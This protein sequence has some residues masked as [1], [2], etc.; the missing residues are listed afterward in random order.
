[1]ASIIQTAIGLSGTPVDVSSMPYCKRLI[2]SASNRFNQDNIVVFGSF[3]G[4]NYISLAGMV[5]PK[6]LSIFGPYKWLKCTSPGSSGV[7]YV[8]ATFDNDVQSVT[9]TS[10]V[11]IPLPGVGPVG[12]GSAIVDGVPPNP[13]IWSFLSVPAVGWSAS[14]VQ[15]AGTSITV[16]ATGGGTNVWVSTGGT[17]GA[18]PIPAALQAANPPAGTLV[19]DNTVTWVIAVPWTA[20]TPYSSTSS[21]PSIV[22]SS[23]STYQCAASGVSVGTTGP[24]PFV[25][26]SN[27][28]IFPTG[29]PE[30]CNVEYANGASGDSLFL[31]SSPDG[32]NVTSAVSPGGGNVQFYNN[33]GVGAV[34]L[35]QRYIRANVL[36]YGGGQ[37]PTGTLTLQTQENNIG[38]SGVTASA[39]QAGPSGII[40]FTSLNASIAWIMETDV[41]AA[42]A[43]GK[44]LGYVGQTGGAGAGSTAGGA[45]GATLIEGGAGGAG[46]SGAAAGAGGG[47]LITAGAAGADAGGGGA[48][49]G[50]VAIVAGAGTGTTSGGHGGDV[51]IVAGNA[52]ASAGARGGQVVIDGGNGSGA[53]NGGFVQLNAGQGGATGQ[54]AEMLLNGGP[55]GATSGAGGAVRIIGGNATT[56]G[57]GGLV[58]VAGGTG[59][60]TGNGGAMQF[61]G[62]PSDPAVGTGS[63]GSVSLEGGSGGGFN[64]N[65]GDCIVLGGQVMSTQGSGGNLNLQGGTGGGNQGDGGSVT[66]TAGELGFDDASRRGWQREHQRWSVAQRRWWP[67]QHHGGQRWHWK[68]G[69]ERD[70]HSWR[71]RHRRRFWWRHQRRRRER[72][73]DRR[74]RWTHRHRGR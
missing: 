65:G 62:G 64:G 9:P 19:T 43:A 55:G 59:F 24:G 72:W 46:V 13:V 51:A 67:R 45:G 61:V 36:G 38:G 30:S 1:M 7:L 60:G 14:T 70:R 63:G 20:S 50:A 34:G 40:P 28:T 17:T 48:A 71:R 56:L 4:V 53:N 57:N 66:I 69:R 49:G 10:G 26:T 29:C 2:Y 3:D 25:D 44:Q 41:A 11:N 35:N 27:T 6:V 54:G 12:T 47:V 33:G 5:G 68:R 18:G 22:F 16:A 39:L 74:Y 21:P 58:R 73:L 32:V 37:P 52:T 31:E 23:G 42:G 8:C 15:A